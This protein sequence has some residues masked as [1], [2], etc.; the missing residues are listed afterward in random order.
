MM[1]LFWWF[2]LGILSVVLMI[3]YSYVKNKIIGG[4]SII[5]RE[6][7]F[8]GIIFVIFG[9]LSLLFI[10]FAIIWDIFESLNKE[11]IREWM[12]KPLF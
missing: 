1:L 9:G 6:D 7:V 5:R 10:I 4:Y 3:V 12:K 2:G 11:K 8:Y